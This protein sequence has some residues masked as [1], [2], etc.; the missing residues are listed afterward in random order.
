VRRTAGGKDD[1]S[2]DKKREEKEDLNISFILLSC[3]LDTEKNIAMSGC[4]ELGQ[5]PIAQADILLASQ[6]G[7]RGENKTNHRGGKIP[8]QM[9]RNAMRQRERGGGRGCRSESR[10]DQGEEGVTCLWR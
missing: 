9:N 2:K 7:G 6:R 1:V 10:Q 4:E 8:Y 3:L 5:E